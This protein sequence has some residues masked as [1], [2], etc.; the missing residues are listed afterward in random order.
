MGFSAIPAMTA[1]TLIVMTTIPGPEPINPKTP[2]IILGTTSSNIP[3]NIPPGGA[4]R[5]CQ[6]SMKYTLIFR[7]IFSEIKTVLYVIG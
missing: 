3:V 7:I 1:Y 6:I 5:P 2:V 4:S